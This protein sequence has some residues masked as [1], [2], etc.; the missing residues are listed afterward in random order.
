MEIELDTQ[1]IYEKIYDFLLEKGLSHTAF[2]LRNE[3]RLNNN[4][5]ENKL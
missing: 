2:V 1:E 5:K 3:A 4:F